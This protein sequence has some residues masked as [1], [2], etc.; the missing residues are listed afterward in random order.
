[1]SVSMRY[2]CSSTGLSRDSTQKRVENADVSSL[3]VGH[4]VL[5]HRCIL[6][7][8]VL[9]RCAR[10]LVSTTMA[11]CSF[12]VDMPGMVLIEE[13]CDSFDVKKKS[14]RESCLVDSRC[15]WAS[16]FSADNPKSFSQTLGIGFSW[17]LLCV[18]QQ[19]S[20]QLKW[21]AK[22]MVA[23]LLPTSV[24]TCCS[25]ASK[26]SRDSLLELSIYSRHLRTMAGLHQPVLP[27]Q[28]PVHSS[29]SHPWVV[30]CLPWGLLWSHNASAV[31]C[32]I[33]SNRNIVLGQEFRWAHG[34]VELGFWHN[35]DIRHMC[36]SS[37]SFPFMLFT[38]ITRKCRLSSHDADATHGYLCWTSH[39][40]SAKSC[41]R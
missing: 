11:S 21:P 12:A 35:Q 2:H 17:R 15:S 37:A 32:T 39:W 25:V 33:L 22:M 27:I 24:D 7:G 19:M 38:L 18:S 26:I 40:I 28:R 36:T 31:Q 1:M 13:T 20:L 29:S 14:R 30:F 5:L 10:K 16:P 34:L 4:C 8:L 9:V 23:L 6:W 41:R 3:I